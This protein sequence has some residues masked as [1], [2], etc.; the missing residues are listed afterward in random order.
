M[1][2]RSRRGIAAI[3]A[4]LTL[5]G[6]TDPQDDTYLPALKQ[7]PMATWTPAG[8]DKPTRSHYVPYNNSNAVT[9]KPQEAKIIRVFALSD[10]AAAT[11]AATAGLKAAE[12]AGWMTE[13]LEGTHKPMA[14]A[15]AWLSVL[16]SST[17]PGELTVTLRLGP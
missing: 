4:L 14:G 10:P 7:D 15:K 5:T 1:R 17:N 9:G 2:Y 16:P 6:C 8:V 12:E 13:K 3:T 11:A